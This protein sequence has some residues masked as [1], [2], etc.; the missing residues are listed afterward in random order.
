MGEEGFTSRIARFCCLLF[1]INFLTHT[2]GVGALAGDT[3]L[4]WPN[5][6]SYKQK[7]YLASQDRHS[8]LQVA[9]QSAMHV[10]AQ[11]LVFFNWTNNLQNWTKL[12]GMSIG[13]G[14]SADSDGKKYINA[15]VLLSGVLFLMP[16]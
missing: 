11:S 16:L 10:V 8:V 1:N 5:S 4:V 7:F 9:C 2:L 13:D 14:I 3:G 12:T 6:V 15:V